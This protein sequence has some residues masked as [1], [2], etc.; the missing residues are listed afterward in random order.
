LDNPEIRYLGDLQRLDLKSGDRFV[1]TV[2]RPLSMDQHKRIQEAWRLFV[3]GDDDKL[4]LL[5][6]DGGLKIGVIGDNAS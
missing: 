6:L 4:K 1:L 3:G 2:D 5:I